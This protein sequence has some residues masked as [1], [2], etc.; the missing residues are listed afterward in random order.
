[1]T[2]DGQALILLA[3]GAAVGL[4]IGL[5]VLAFVRLRWKS[6]LAE[7][8]RREREQSRLDEER[9]E[10]FHLAAE[11]LSRT[12]DE[13]A[14]AQFRSHTRN[15]LQ[16]AREN[17]DVHHEKAKGELKAREKAIDGLLAPIK[18]TLQ[19]TEVQLQ[20]FDKARRES[21]GNITAQLQ[22]MAAAQQSLG[23]ETRNLVNAL[24]RPEVRGQWGEM[25][26]RRLV[27]L[28]GMVEHCDFITQSH[29]AT[30]TGAIRPDMIVSLPEG[31]QLVVD[32][33][34]PLDAY[35]E[36]T[37]APDDV[38]RRGAFSRHA[39]IVANRVRELSSKAYWNQ[40]DNT[41]EFVILFVPGD[42]FL[43][44]ALAERPDL[45][46][47]ALQQNVILATP[48]S[49]VALLKA[50]AYGWRQVALAENATVIRKLAVE[51]YDRLA[52]FSGHLAGIGKSLGDSV[53]AYNRGIGSLEQMVLPSARKFKELG[54]QPR[55]ELRDLSDVDNNLRQLNSD[56]T[57]AEDSDKGPDLD[58]DKDSDSDSDS[59]S[60]TDSEKN[61]GT[62]E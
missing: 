49:L 12:F 19:R 57:A 24:R 36:A 56:D 18:E 26:L 6:A 43:T 30:D 32:V 61:S 58:T 3:A 39:G 2:L 47:Q 34:T 50:V 21:H 7:S 41:P 60:D 38:S 25:T 51:L 5:T 20:E 53:K 37:E 8:E 45:L 46:D 62:D 33:K 9:D 27:E 54:I 29:K 35:L 42:Q 11:R 22:A 16:L 1:M 55:N 4:I 23:A 44:A 28:A 10:I 31:R 14:D 15:F 17:L 48:T 40:F 13:L 59:G 52:T